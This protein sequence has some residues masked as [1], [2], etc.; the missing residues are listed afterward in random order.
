MT[1]FVC[2][3]RVILII[4]ITCARE[5]G[6]KRT[7]RTASAVC[8]FCRDV[9]VV[10]YPSSLLRLTRSPCLFLSLAVQGRFLPH[11]WTLGCVAVCLCWSPDFLVAACT[12]LNIPPAAA[13]CSRSRTPPPSPHSVSLLFF[14]GI[15]WTE[16][17]KSRKGF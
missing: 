3:T 12:Y 10:V 4:L 1:A 6:R 7:V 11:S 5:R 17:L 2:K 13:L 16:G 9:K 15:S 14:A 8:V